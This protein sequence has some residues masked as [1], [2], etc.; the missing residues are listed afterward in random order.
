MADTTNFNRVRVGGSGFTVFHWRNQPLAFARQ[1]SHTS[2]APVGPG[3]VPIHPMDT[4]YPVQVITP[5]AAG[6]GTLTLELY[7][8]YGAQI[9]ERLGASAGQ[10]ATGGDFNGAVDIVNI[11]RVQAALRDPI[12]VVKYIKPPMLRGSTMKAYTEE[13]HN[14][15]ITNVLDGETIEIGTME[16]LK[17]IT[18]GYTH[19]TRGGRRG[20]DTR[21]SG[22]NASDARDSTTTQFG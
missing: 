5:Q 22:P 8:L 18:I 14:A 16:V 3:P 2:T 6:M 7:E 11:F 15:V 12:N 19:V 17:Q 4:P 20:D 9:W 13:Y 1:V 21:E 10:Q